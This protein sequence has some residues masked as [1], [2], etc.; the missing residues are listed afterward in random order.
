MR[1]IE[2]AI[3][4]RKAVHIPLVI[5]QIWLGP[6]R[7]PLY[8]I[9]SCRRFNPAWLHVLWTEENLP[10]MAN[11]KVF[12]AFDRTWYAKADILRY[13]VLHRFGGVYVDAD[14]LC[15]RS[16][17][18]L[19]NTGEDFFA[20]YQNLGN[21]DLDEERR[22]ASLIANAV[23]G[24]S[25]H[26]PILEAVISDIGAG[27][28]RKEQPW[29]RVGPGALTKAVQETHA[30]AVIYPFH[31]FYPYHSTETIPELPEEMLKATHY[32]SRSVSLWGSTL[33]NYGRCR[34]LTRRKTTIE[35]PQVTPDFAS[36]YPL[37]APTVYHGPNERYQLL[38]AF[39]STK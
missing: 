5:H 37:Q 29:V 31:E 2:S 36:R 12:D 28:D 26:H 13:E 30:R 19:V 8:T 27:R 22:R 4:R 15:L 39:L 20:G 17:D 25:P 11:R 3:A 35:A 9:E 21:P 16:F 33:G 32:G 34:N 1:E 23:I 18:D 10:P 38:N 7:P 14:Q 24:A 6:E